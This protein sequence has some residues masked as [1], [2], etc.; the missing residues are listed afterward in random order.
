MKT[1]LGLSTA[2]YVAAHG[3]PP[4]GPRPWAFHIAGT[5]LAVDVE[6]LCRNSMRQERSFTQCPIARWYGCAIEVGSPVK[7]SFRRCLFVEAKAA[8]RSLLC[9]LPNRNL[10]LIEVVP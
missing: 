6:L 3:T 4:R 9:N 2:A 8:L 7:V 10:L 5:V 1:M